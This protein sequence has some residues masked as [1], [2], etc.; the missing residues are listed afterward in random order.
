MIGCVRKSNLLVST[1]QSRKFP[2]RIN[3]LKNGLGEV[4]ELK[5]HL[6]L[7]RFPSIYKQTPTPRTHFRRFNLIDVMTNP[8]EW[9]ISCCEMAICRRMKSLSMKQI[10]EPTFNCL[11]GGFNVV[12]DETSTSLFFY[13]QVFTD[14][15]TIVVHLLFSLI[16]FFFFLLSNTLPGAETF[17]QK[18]NRNSWD[19]KLER[20][21]NRLHRQLRSFCHQDGMPNC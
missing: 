7:K 2:E 18:P 10:F 20:A 14:A 5:T 15:H 3:H 11:H 9:K 19:R 16:F 21:Q 8:S 13:A 6:A 4:L 1:S 17:T 12:D